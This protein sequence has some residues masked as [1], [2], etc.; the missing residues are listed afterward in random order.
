MLGVANPMA[1]CTATGTGTARPP[2]NGQGWTC[3][4]SNH[5]K[6]PMTPA[7]VCTSQYGAGAY[8]SD[9]SPTA[10]TWRCYR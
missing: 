4:D 3:V 5:H 8:P 10:L 6:T 2:R 1:Y 7:Q 9:T